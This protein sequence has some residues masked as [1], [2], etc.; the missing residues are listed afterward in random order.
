MDVT[1]LEA[2]DALP[3]VRSTVQGATVIVL[4]PALPDS[5]TVDVPSDVDSDVVADARLN[6][7]VG[8]DIL[9]IEFSTDANADALVVAMAPFD[10]STPLKEFV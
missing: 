9:D 8:T 2:V 6:V 3:D 10:G 7:L 4:T 5:Y 1:F